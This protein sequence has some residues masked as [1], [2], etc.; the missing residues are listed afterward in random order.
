MLMKYKFG[1]KKFVSLMLLLCVFLISNVHAQKNR[2]I[3]SNLLIPE[4]AAMVEM[5]RRNALLTPAKRRILD[6]NIN[7]LVKS[8]NGTWELVYRMV[9]NRETD[10]K[11]IIVP[12]TGTMTFNLKSEGT[13]AAGDFLVME[14]GLGNR[15]ISEDVG[16]N[17]PFSIGSYNR[18]N[19]EA[20]FTG[21]TPTGVNKNSFVQQDENVVI[22]E[23][24][25][26]EVVGSYG[27]FRK[28]V[29]FRHTSENLTQYMAMRTERSGTHFIARNAFLTPGSENADAVDPFDIIKLTGDVMVLG[30]SKKGLI[31]VWRKTSPAIQV[32]GK[33]IKSYWDSAKT[34]TKF[35]K[36]TFKK[37][38]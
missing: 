35:S 9:S 32:Q 12:T 18:V 27:I 10:G 8:L 30:I 13:R 21:N 38:Q 20:G 29:I 37:A 3:G 24:I 15:V 26:G 16:T 23:Q 36:P 1:S 33:S 6:Q 17:E 7:E 19:F 2:G 11:V 22:S 5:Q 4:D 14:E 25:V 28:P 31:D 34:G